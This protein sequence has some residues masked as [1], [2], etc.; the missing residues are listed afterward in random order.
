MRVSCSTFLTLAALA[1]LGPKALA[2]RAGVTPRVTDTVIVETKTIFAQGFIPGPA[3]PTRAETVVIGTVVEIEPDVVEIPA[4]RGA[5]KDQNVRYKVAILK[6]DERVLGAA[7]VT[8]VRIGFPAD[9]LP[10]A[11]PRSG[12]ARPAAIT[13]TVGGYPP[14]VALTSGLAGCFALTRR[15]GTDFYVLEGLPLRKTQANYAKEVDRLKKYAAAINDP[16]AALR[17]KDVNDRFEAALILLQRYQNVRGTT[18]REPIPEEENKLIVALLNELPWMPEGG[19]RIGADGK[20]IPH[21]SA[22]WY[23]TNPGEFG[24]KQ[25]PYPKHKPGEPPVDVNKLLDEATT[26]FL[27]ENGDKIRIRRFVQK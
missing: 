14:G 18:A 6:I 27:K 2:Q 5:P 23:T 25:P 20:L 22:L 21:R 24:F 17:A 16:V 7:G 26:Q 11:G 10:L 4:Y 15:P 3:G 9:A 1:A 12:S 19:R 8:R 13:A